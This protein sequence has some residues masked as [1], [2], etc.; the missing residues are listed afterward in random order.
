[1]WKWRA[2]RAIKP[3]VEEYR[4]AAERVNRGADD[5]LG[6]WRA[7]GQRELRCILMTAWDP[8]GVGDAPEAW[9]EYDRYEPGVAYRLRDA[10]DPDEAAK[11]VA[12]YLDHVERDF[13]ECLT[14]EGSRKNRY[15]ANALVAWHEWS[16]EKGGRP[17]QEWLP[18]A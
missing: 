9:D 16:F 11:Q 1:V 3:I 12:E 15:L 17:P 18:E 2:R 6:W 8:I 13:I 4:A 7:G 5:W 10:A 14:N